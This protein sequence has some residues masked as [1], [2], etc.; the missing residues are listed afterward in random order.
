MNELEQKLEQYEK[1][2]VSVANKMHNPN[3][4]TESSKEVLEN[5]PNVRLASEKN[6]IV[7]GGSKSL[8]SP[9][10]KPA[11]LALATGLIAYTVGYC[12]RNNQNYSPQNQTA[13]DFIELKQSYEKT[14]NNIVD[15]KEFRE[16]FIR[17]FNIDSLTDFYSKQFFG[18]NPDKYQTE[19]IKERIKEELQ[20]E[21]R[22]WKNL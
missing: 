17:L 19:Y 7:K 8:F 15:K 16:G 5:F 20:K 18:E 22:K 11:M 10:L 12:T 1:T 9:F 4:R 2:A 3:L 6:N 13:K 14:M 21:V